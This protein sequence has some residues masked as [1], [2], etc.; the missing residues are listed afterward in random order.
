MRGYIVLALFL[1]AAGCTAQETYQAEEE[2]DGG[3]DGGSDAT[4]NH[5]PNTANNAWTTTDREEYIQST[6]HSKLVNEH[7]LFIKKP[8]QNY[9]R[10][11]GEVLKLRCDFGGA[12]TNAKLKLSWL[13]ND[14]PVDDIEDERI[15]IK[16]SGVHSTRLRINELAFLDQGF[17]TCVAESEDGKYGKAESTSV[18]K[19]KLGGMDFDLSRKMHTGNENSFN[20]FAFAGRNPASGF[21]PSG[22]HTDF[23]NVEGTEFHPDDPNTL[24]AGG[25][26]ELYRGTT[27][28]HYLANQTVYVRP[29]LSI[30]QMEEKL[31]GAF[32]VVATSHDVSAECHKYAI[33][34]LCMFAFP[35]CDKT[36]HQPKPRIVCRDEC[37][38]L[39]DN[40]CRM[41]YSIAKRHPVIGRANILP[42][43]KKL[44]DRHTREGSNCL[45][46]GI[47][48]PAIIQLNEDQ[49]CYDSNG[50]NYRGGVAQGI[51]GAPCQPWHHQILYSRVAEHPG[52]I[53]GHSYCRNPDASEMGP[54]CFTDGNRK[55]ICNIPKCAD[56]IWLYVIVPSV[57][58]VAL[59][60][61]LIS[62][63]C[64][65]RRAT[66]KPPPTSLVSNSLQAL[67][68]S[69]GKNGTQ[70][71]INTMELN[72]LLP[73][74]R[75]RAPE[76]P[77][78]SIRFSEELGEG[79]FGKVY[80]G[81]IIGYDWLATQQ[82]ML[83]NRFL[84]GAP[85]GEMP[86]AIKTLKENANVKTQ[87]DFQRE[88]ELMA[89]LHHPNIV[90]L[91]GVVTRQEPMCLLFEYMS[92][93]DLHEF[94]IAHSPSRA[95]SINQ[96]L[97]FS[98]FLH[99][100]RQI[101]AG[102]EFL[103]AHHYVHRD[104][105]ARNCLVGENMT[106]KISDFGL[107]RDI[108]SSDYYRVQSK[109]LLPVRWMPPEAILYGKF[110][111]ESDVWSFGVVMWEVFSYG[112][113]P[114]YGY[115]N[116]E[117]I[118]MIRARQLL[119]CPDECPSHVYSMMVECWHEVSS[120]R[121][122][123]TELHSRLGS[124]Q[125]MHA[126]S[127]SQGSRSQSST[128]NSTM[129]SQ[130]KRNL[131]TSQDRCSTPNSHVYQHL[132]HDPKA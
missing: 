48:L 91:V 13:R 119:A 66:S 2:D 22:F 27:C 43:C 23:S 63:F 35:P 34:S 28:Q 102:M 93:G 120:R 123:F 98:D 67:K 16:N 94:L 41:E 21:P 110:T 70:S 38:L 106:V 52:I 124:W 57:A 109:S 112:C 88:A 90:C 128:T 7:K 84:N 96:T 3:Q 15:V 101:A 68:V 58:A 122:N 103:A 72:K 8:L 77:L 65:R 6:P 107:S 129:L 29:G 54:W 127:V 53:G 111:A 64:I 31:A 99:V 95:D 132:I 47:P 81:S 40:I 74:T 83:N 61:L 5:K 30:A 4:A 125:A 86:V 80:R 56:Y 92:H 36:V 51:S 82:P 79:A 97:E 14:A 12:P 44:P 42:D 115:T 33:P 126:R 62:V 46:L 26:C 1:I 114:Y 39:E 49:N 85:N 100:C 9:T 45:T 55:E 105:A 25:Q 71:R 17:Y 73:R 50:E 10:S 104:L 19:I 37:E 75:V 24:I 69:G 59:V 78:S 130:Q 118:D 18:L 89:D 117:V 131:D 60:S 11:P 113:Q 76:F 20:P 108:Y 87:H 121:P 32:T 116:Q